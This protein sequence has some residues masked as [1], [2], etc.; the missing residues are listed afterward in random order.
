M[1]NIDSTLEERGTKYGSFM[2]HAR[3]AQAIKAAMVDSP[4]WEKLAPDMREALD[5]MAQKVGRILNGDFTYLDSWHD[6]IGYIRLVEQRLEQEEKEKDAANKYEVVWT[7]PNYTSGPIRQYGNTVEH[8]GILHVQED[9]FPTDAAGAHLPIFRGFD[10]TYE[11]WE[12]DGRVERYDPEGNRV[13]TGSA[14]SR[15]FRGRGA[16][17]NSLYDLTEGDSGGTIPV[18]TRDGDG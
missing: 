10:G 8:C 9:L 14:I 6:I 12:Q 16:A 13:G 11:Y 18:A 15:L 7:V 17:F 3:I 1:S 2:E 5:M 4:N